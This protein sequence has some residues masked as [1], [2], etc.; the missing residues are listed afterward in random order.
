MHKKGFSLI[1]LSISL[2]IISLIIAAIAGGNHLIRTARLQRVISELTDYAKAV[3]QFTLTYHHL[4]G[5]MPTATAF[6]SNVQNGDGNGRIE[7]QETEQLQAWSHLAHAHLITGSF[8][9][10]PT[11]GTMF[12]ANI[13][14]PASSIKEAYYI[15][16]YQ[17]LYPSSGSGHTGHTIQLVSTD[18]SLYP[19][20]GALSASDAR[21]I[22]KKLDESANPANGNIFV[23]RSGIEHATQGS[24]VTTDYTTATTADYE[25]DDHTESCR[26]ALWIQ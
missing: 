15:V 20:G 6:W 14:V 3:D 13:N 25:M 24:C 7:G 8:T 16:G 1:E 26:L 11:E 17:E 22:D 18:S 5:D 23:F 19:E 12:E 4:P 9:G 2:V 21:L 10:E